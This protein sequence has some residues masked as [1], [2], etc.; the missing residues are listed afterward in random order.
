MYIIKN[1]WK[2]ISRNKGRNILIMIIALVIAI[3]ACLSLSIREA[4]EKA[5]EDTLNGLSITAQLSFDRTSV[6]QGMNQSSDNT[7][8]GKPFDRGNFDFSALSG[9]SLTYE[10]YMS[11]AALLAP[12]DSYYYTLSLSMNATGDLL[13]YGEEESDESDGPDVPDTQTSGGKMGMNM[14]S[15][16]F[17]IIGYSSYDALFALFGEDGTHTI[18]E[19]TMFDETSSVQECIISDELAMYNGLSVGDTITLSNPDYEEETYDLTIVGLYTN[20]ASDTGNS[21]FSMSDPANNIYMNSTAIQGIL[22]LSAA[23]GNVMTDSDGNDSS[24]VISSE[25]SFTYVLSNI[26]NYEAFL[27]AAEA[28]GLPENYTLSSSDFS[29]YENSITPLNTLSTMTGWFFLIVLIIGGIILVVINVF[30]LR[31]RKYEVGVL[32]AIGMKKSKVAMQFVCE[33]FIITFIAITVGAAVG[34]TASVPVTN[35]LLEQQVEKAEASNEQVN[36]NFGGKMDLMNNTATQPT[37][38]IDSVSSATDMTVIL[39]MV[40]VGVLLT[41][42]SSMAAMVS[43]MRYEPLQILSDRS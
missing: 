13:P 9:S 12:D 26:E 23:A 25:I 6:M 7:D 30:N 11:Y 33:L 2:S 39:Q 16:D 19:G 35:T 40:L 36:N 14:S 42:I 24:A 4:A 34:A 1:A 29:S 31:E 22:D 43:I 8:S 3:S 15:S 17:N 10:D 18:S 20:S 32:T 38:Y 27:A 21:R 41:I 28:Q 5:K 37:N